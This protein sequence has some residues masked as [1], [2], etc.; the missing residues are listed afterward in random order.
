VL[1]LLLC[2]ALVFV[3]IPVVVYL[4]ISYV[5]FEKPHVDVSVVRTIEKSQISEEDLT[6]VRLR[7]TNVGNGEIPFLSISDAVPG[8]L[9]DSDVTQSSFGM[10]LRKGETKD[11]F[12]AVRGNVFGVFRLGP[13][14]AKSTDIFGLGE[15]EK[16]LDL[17]SNI[18]VLPKA[19]ERLIH[20]KIRPR[21]TKPWP[22]EIAARKV[23]LGIDNFS[24]RQYIP[25][26][27]F[28]RINWRASARMNR[29]NDEDLF[30]NEQMAELGADTI[31]IVDARPVSNVGSGEDSTIE[32]SVHVAISVTDRLLKDR[33][34]VGLITVGLNSEKIPPGYGRRQ[35]N[36]LVLSLIRVRPGEFFTFENISRYLKLFYPNIAQV[37]LISPLIDDAAFSSAAEIARTGYELLVISPHPIDFSGAEKEKKTT[38][39]RKRNMKKN[40]EWKIASDLAELRRESNLSLLRRSGALVVDWRKNDSLDFVLSK[41]VRAW[42]RRQMEISRGR[43]R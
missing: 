31:V 22:G 18:V 11:V 19:T 13:I 24:I 35:Y 33:N 36:R 25:G 32:Y 43:V 14:S 4:C 16:Q 34:R 42:S 27:S 6:R 20:F 38:T 12:Y 28:R 1:G 39:E 29:E 15:S 37:V 2:G 40:K 7:V 3:S 10:A 21:K 30:L 8:E 41:N 26:D 17:Y 9:W 5:Q 23:G